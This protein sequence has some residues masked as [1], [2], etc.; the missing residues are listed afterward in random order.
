MFEDYIVQALE[1]D[2]VITI[3]MISENNIISVRQFVEE[4]DDVLVV[5]DTFKD[6]QMIVKRNISTVRIDY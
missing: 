2:R 1:E 6:V 3:K 4:S 5:V